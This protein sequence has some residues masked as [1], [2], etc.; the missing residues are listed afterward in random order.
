MRAWQI[1]ALTRQEG[2]QAEE[3]EGTEA[4]RGMEECLQSQKKEEVIRGLKAWRR[5]QRPT[6]P[7]N[8]G[9]TDITAAAAAAASVP[10]ARRHDGPEDKTNDVGS[11][12]EQGPE[13]ASDLLEEIV[14]RLGDESAVRAE[15]TWKL[16]AY[17]PSLFLRQDRRR[18]QASFAARCRRITAFWE[19]DFGGLVRLLRDDVVLLRERQQRRRE[20][21]SHRS[22]QQQAE[23][24]LKSKRKQVKG[25]VEEGALSKAASWLQSLG[26]APATVA[27]FRKMAGMFLRR[28]TPLR[29]RLNPSH[30]P[31]LR[32]SPSLGRIFWR[33]CNP[34]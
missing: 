26:V 29:L 16:L 9:K 27:T 34:R 8:S 28:A 21:R 23:N 19:G 32:L 15:R 7:V 10:Q 18:G 2:R 11:E 25:L 1:R 17:F 12:D 14:D 4:R 22:V 33:R 30:S 24:D 5:R 13:E 6:M 3:K 20:R 31:S